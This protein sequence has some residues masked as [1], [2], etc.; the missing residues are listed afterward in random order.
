MPVRDTDWQVHAGK[1]Q[2]EEM[3]ARRSCRFFSDRP[4]DRR[5]L[6]LAIQIGHSAPSGA[7]R[8]PWRF[9]VVDDPALKREIRIAAEKRNGKAT[10]MTTFGAMDYQ[11]PILSHRRPQSRRTQTPDVAG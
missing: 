7:N 3:N 4:V 8:N 11:T 9:V 5:V 10:N 6:E 1:S 2:L